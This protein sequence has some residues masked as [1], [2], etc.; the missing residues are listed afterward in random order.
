MEMIKIK[1]DCN[2]EDVS[3][4]VKHMHLLEWLT[5]YICSVYGTVPQHR[6]TLLANVN[7]IIYIDKIY[8]TRYAVHPP[9]LSIFVKMRLY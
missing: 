4:F 9:V 5:S 3:I 8:R 1:F 6:L 7:K 2:S